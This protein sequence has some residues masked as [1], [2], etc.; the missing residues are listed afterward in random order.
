[1]E[2]IGNLGEK[3]W[4]LVPAHVKDLKVLSTFENQIKKWIPTDCP[5]RLCKESVAEVGFL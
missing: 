5:C 3:I 1:M 2:F 4:N